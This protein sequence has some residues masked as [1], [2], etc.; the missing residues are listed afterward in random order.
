M[1]RGRPCVLI[2]E[3]NLLIAMEVEFMVE[4]CGCSVAGPA[5]NVADAL[6][7]V[8]E[9]NLQG[10]VLDINLGR[11]R[12]WQVAETLAD[13]AVPFVLAT[14][15]GD[16]EVPAQFKERPVLSKPISR[17]ALAKALREIGTLA[18]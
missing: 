9:N 3:D 13:R 14:G 15:Y 11:E 12:V 1:N 16:A 6:Q 4:D 2:V 18:D 17:G 5:G 10:A 8:S 7:V